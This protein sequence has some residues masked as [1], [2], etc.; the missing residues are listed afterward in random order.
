M[1]AYRVS[2]YVHIYTFASHFVYNVSADSSYSCIQAKPYRQRPSCTALSDPTGL[3][4]A[5]R[6][7]GFH[8]CLKGA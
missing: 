2:H 4:A 3:S 7:R 1:F 8:N 5:R 6:L